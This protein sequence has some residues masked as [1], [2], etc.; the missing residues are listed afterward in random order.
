MERHAHTV[1]GS[2][3]AVGNTLDGDCFLGLVVD[4]MAGKKWA[5]EDP[6][7][8]YIPSKDNQKEF[9]LVRI[10]GL[11]LTEGQPLS[12]GSIPAR[13]PYK[14]ETKRWA[15]AQI[16][17]SWHVAGP[18]VVSIQEFLKQCKICHRLGM[19]FRMSG[20]TFF[21]DLE[22][23]VEYLLGVKRPE[24]EISFFERKFFAMLGEILPQK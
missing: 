24:D 5:D 2:L 6:C 12:K 3:I 7:L 14:V 10:L 19:K 17:R 9:V 13:E 21:H 16:N 23:V 4:Q 11:K 22:L 1:V 15:F 18:N 20:A 8:D